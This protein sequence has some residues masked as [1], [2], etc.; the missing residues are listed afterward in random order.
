MATFNELFGFV[1]EADSAVKNQVAWACWNA[2]K[3]IFQEA[4]TIPDHTERI[5]YAKALL[6][7]D[8]TGQIMK[9]I[10]RM[11]LIVLAKAGPY[12]D[13]EIEIAVGQIIDKVA[14]AGA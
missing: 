6:A 1:R 14:V 13:A 11:T 2:A 3:S 4:D 12:A 9:R 7:D 8:G 10:I 5:A